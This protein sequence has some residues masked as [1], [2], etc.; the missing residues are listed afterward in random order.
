MIPPFC[1]INIYSILLEH[2]RFA[3]IAYEHKNASSK[4]LIGRKKNQCETQLFLDQ[5]LIIF[6]CSIKTV[7]CNDLAL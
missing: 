1:S 7:L 3:V 2:Q 5:K 6:D 4:L